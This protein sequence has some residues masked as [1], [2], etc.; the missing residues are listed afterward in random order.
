MPSAPPRVWW[1]PCVPVCFF[2]TG[3]ALAVRWEPWLGQSK[4]H[5]LA[6]SFS[7]NRPSDSSSSCVCPPANALPPPPPHPAP[8]LPTH[9]MSNSMPPPPPLLTTSVPRYF[10]Q[11]WWAWKM[12]H[13]ERWESIN[14][15][16]TRRRRLTLFLPLFAFLYNNSSV[17]NV[18]ISAVVCSAGALTFT[19]IWHVTF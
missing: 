4:G 13:G 14:F 3:P 5:T 8:L 10:L 16:A 12:S 17:C 19:P 2:G 9:T 7:G 15:H 18:N 11:R 1:E 6:V